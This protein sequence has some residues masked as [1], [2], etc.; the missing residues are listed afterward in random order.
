MPSDFKGTVYQK[1]EWDI[2]VYTGLERTTNNF[3]VILK[4]ILLS[5]YMENMLKGK[6]IVNIKQISNTMRNMMLRGC[7]FLT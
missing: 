1:M 2:T 7:C 4:Q 6:K 3:S 5:A